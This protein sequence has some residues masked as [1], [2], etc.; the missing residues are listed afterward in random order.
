MQAV[1]NQDLS[2]VIGGKAGQ[3]SRK[4]G[5]I[6]AEL[7]NQLGYQIYIYND[8]PSLIRGG[9]NFSQLRITKQKKQTHRQ[10]I[11]FLLAL[12]QKTLNKH[13]VNLSEESIIFYDQDQIQL[14]KNTLPD[15]HLIALSLKSFNLDAPTIMSN[16]MLISALAK[17]LDLDLT[18]VETVLEK[19]FKSKAEINLKLAQG[20]YQH[21]ETESSLPLSLPLSLPPIENTKPVELVTGNETLALGAAKAGL[22][23]YLAYPMTPATGILHYLAQNGAQLG[24]KTVQLENEI[25]VASAALGAAY[26]GR[27]TMLGTSGGGFALMVETLSLAVQNESPI[28]FVESQRSG[29]ASGVPTYTQQADLSFVLSAGHGDITKFVIAPSDADEAYEWG[30][31]ALNLAWKYQTP[32]ILL[33][34]KQISESTFS[35]NP[36]E[37]AEVKA[38]SYLKWN[39]QKPYQRYQ[40]TESGLSPLA[41]PG[42][43]G[44]TV[45]SNSYEHDEAGLTTEVPEKVTA[46]QDK[47]ARKFAQ[48]QQEVENLK[49]VKTY[50]PKTA[51]KA[52]ITWG[53]NKGALLEAVE[54][55]EIRIIQP[56]ILEPFP[57]QQ[58]KS[59]LAGVEK[60]AVLEANRQGQLAQLLTSFGLKTD[61]KILKYD[62][63][64]FLPNKIKQKLENF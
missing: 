35:F 45:K 23:L 37:Q 40:L 26:T 44:A 60:I 33:I 49:A 8:Y 28:V 3:G 31:K 34:D 30:A 55:L 62:G 24:V 11:D 32:V 41:F 61:K 58:L 20:V 15:N 14:D 7:L 12:D 47:R 22:E 13:Q 21:L 4:A 48:M 19:E 52:V 59:A 25:G 39:G 43:T 54:D 63:R 18:L 2:I 51:S 17:T 56:L 10:K 57:L 36:D 29:P 64:P 46:M 16:T 27:K 1:Q 6:I 38:S 9:H 42:Q 53:S 5:L 50:G